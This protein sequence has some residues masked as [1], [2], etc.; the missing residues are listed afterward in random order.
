MLKDVKVE[1]VDGSRFNEDL[2][3]RLDALMKEFGLERWASGFDLCDLVR[4][5][6]YRHQEIESSMLTMA[7][8]SHDNLTNDSDHVETETT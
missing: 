2:E 8:N 3:R 1:Y 5:V 4:D 7:T 6:A